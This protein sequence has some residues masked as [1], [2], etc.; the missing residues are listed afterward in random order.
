M[1]AVN[2]IFWIEG[3]PP[4]MLAV[5]L[6]PRGGDWLELELRNLQRGGIQT[7]VSLLEDDEASWLGLADEGPQAR[8]LGMG[9]LSYPIPDTQIPSDCVDFRHF[10]AGLV[11]R[12]RRGEPIGVHCRGSIG[13]STVTVAAALIHLGWK[14]ALALAAIQRARGCAVPDT[15][16]QQRWILH[17]G[18]QA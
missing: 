11:T 18:S 17:Y 13:R 8:A 15:E 4:P 6:R 10:V 9:F 2:E 5:V 14:P 1:T 7:I 3:T 16:E 12:L